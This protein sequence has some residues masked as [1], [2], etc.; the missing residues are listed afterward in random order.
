MDSR[1]F[2]T[3]VF[4]TVAVVCGVLVTAE[5]FY[6]KDG[7]YAAEAWFG[8]H[9]LYGFVSCVLLILA[10]KPLRRLPGRDEDYND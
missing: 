5:L 8:F 6:E 10:A 2:G 4:W 3:R 9:G 7:H 1:A